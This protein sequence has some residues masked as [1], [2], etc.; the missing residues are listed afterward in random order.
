MA[1]IK[2]YR[3]QVRVLESRI[4]GLMGEKNAAI[5]AAKTW[6]RKAQAQQPAGATAW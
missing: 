1:E 2:R 6:Q 3:E 4:N 5:R